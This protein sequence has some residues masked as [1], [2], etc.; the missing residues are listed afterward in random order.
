MKLWIEVALPIADK[1]TWKIEIW[2]N[3]GGKQIF[4]TTWSPSSKFLCYVQNPAPLIGEQSSFCKDGSVA[5][6]EFNGHFTMINTMLW[7]VSSQ[8][9]VDYK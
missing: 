3:E 1:H 4:H 7:H 6:D 9:L 5:P 8:T 2:I